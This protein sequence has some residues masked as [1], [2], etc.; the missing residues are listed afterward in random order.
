MTVVYLADSA[1]NLRHSPKLRRRAR[2]P[3]RW[4]A[5][6]RAGTGPTRAANTL[7]AGPRRHSRRS[8]SSMPNARR[9]PTL[10]RGAAR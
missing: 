10:W 1:P 9:M 2:D 7:R 5:R 4:L 8:S 6:C 3:S